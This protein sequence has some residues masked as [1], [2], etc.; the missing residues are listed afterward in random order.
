MS[1]GAAPN[2]P[3]TG[4]P[5][6]KPGLPWRAAPPPRSG[7]RP[8][9]VTLCQSC[10]VASILSR[11]ARLPGLMWDFDNTALPGRVPFLARIARPRLGCLGPVVPAGL[12]VIVVRCPARRVRDYPGGSGPPGGS[13]TPWGP[14]S[15]RQAISTRLS[16]APR[17]G[18]GTGAGGA[19]RS[20]EDGGSGVAGVAA[21]S[22]AAGGRRPRGHHGAHGGP[23]SQAGRTRPGYLAGVL[24]P[25]AGAPVR[26]K[27][28]MAVPAGR[29]RGDGSHRSSGY[30]VGCGNGCLRHGGADPPPCKASE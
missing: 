25:S 24:A 19:S 29:A 2:V 8:F 10:I 28:R 3:R 15:T 21:A 22:P 14:G 20:R 26:R 5:R 23:W 17:G 9:P 1:P 4:T 13:G 16:A 30:P 11:R 12:G 27:P 6:R 18:R 7:E